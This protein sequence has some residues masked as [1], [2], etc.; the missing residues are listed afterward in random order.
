MAAALTELGAR[1]R[2]RRQLFT[3]R[4]LAE[5]APL[6]D[7]AFP[8]RKALSLADAGQE[9]GKRQRRLALGYRLVRGKSR[10]ARLER[11]AEAPVALVCLGAAAL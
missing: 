2:I 9:R 7:N 4:R 8:G 1:A 10:A 5:T 6:A 11:E 3:G